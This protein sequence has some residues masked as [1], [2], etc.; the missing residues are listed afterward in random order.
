MSHHSE[1][2]FMA[3]SDS[4]WEPGNYKKT[5]KRIDDGNKLCN[6]LMTLVS[7][8]AKLEKEYAVGLKAWAHRWNGVIEKGEVFCGWFF[9]RSIF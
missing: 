2:G 8:R 1:D 3:G 4:F 7:E 9:E 6:E 5:T